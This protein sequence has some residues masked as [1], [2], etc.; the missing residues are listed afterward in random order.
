MSV[1]SAL[2]TARKLP[3]APHGNAKHQDASNKH[4]S[5]EFSTLSNC[6]KNKAML[7]LNL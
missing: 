5:I 6:L 4:L 3:V 7:G 1:L 2:S